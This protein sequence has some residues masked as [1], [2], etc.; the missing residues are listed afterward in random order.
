MINSKSKTG[1]YHWLRIA[2]FGLPLFSNFLFSMELNHYLL[3]FKDG[4]YL[5]TFIFTHQLLKPI[6]SLQLDK[7]VYVVDEKI[8]W[9]NTTLVNHAMYKN[10]LID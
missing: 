2:M 10:I 5:L 3:N 1:Y 6:P 9:Q 7:N 4:Y 8:M